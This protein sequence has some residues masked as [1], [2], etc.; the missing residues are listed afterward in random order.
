MGMRK[1]H[2]KARAF[3]WLQAL[4]AACMSASLRERRDA[5]QFTREAKANEGRGLTFNIVCFIRTHC[6][7]S[8]SDPT[9]L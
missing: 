1:R 9:P 3:G 7:C 6:P 5:L 2:Q 8:P 4:I